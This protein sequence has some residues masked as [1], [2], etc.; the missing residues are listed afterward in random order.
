ME[1]VGVEAL[2]RWKHPARG[3]LPAGAFLPLV[4]DNFLFD[5]LTML[6]VEKSI[7]QCRRW[8]DHG[9][10]VQ[11]SV[12]LSPDLLLDRGHRGPHRSQGAGA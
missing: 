10:D 12:N 5:E 6:I 3:V 9:L 8:R 11:V 2:I 4:A 1:L 7:A